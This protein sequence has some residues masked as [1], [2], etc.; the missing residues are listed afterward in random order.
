MY[1]IPDKYVLRNSIK[2][3]YKSFHILL[4]FPI[5]DFRHYHYNSQWKILFIIHAKFYKIYRVKNIKKIKKV[6]ITKY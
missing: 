1:I 5:I 3:K 6:K 2:Y 4:H